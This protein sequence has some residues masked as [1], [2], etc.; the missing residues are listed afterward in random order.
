M[1]RIKNWVV[2]KVWQTGSTWFHISDGTKD[3]TVELRYP[4]GEIRSY[5]VIINDRGFVRSFSYPSLLAAKLDIQKY[6]RRYP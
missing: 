6:M 4:I 5:R 1:V 3:G 2:A